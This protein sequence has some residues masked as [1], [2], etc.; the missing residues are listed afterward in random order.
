MIPSG[1]LAAACAALQL[2]R[3]GRAFAQPRPR[4]KFGTKRCLARRNRCAAG[5]FSSTG[6]SKFRGPRFATVSLKRPTGISCRSAELEGIRGSL[7]RHG[8]GVGSW[9][10]S[11]RHSRAPHLA[12]ASSWGLL[13]GLPRLPVPMPV[14]RL[15]APGWRRGLQDPGRRRKNSQRDPA[16]WRAEAVAAP[17]C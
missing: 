15:V 6:R 8:K 3:P 10:W 11:Q 1:S 2:A 13:L 14:E 7:F 9:C 5:S 16:E 12:R 4:S 17:R